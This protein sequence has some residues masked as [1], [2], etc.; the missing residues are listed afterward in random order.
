MIQFFC[1]RWGQAH[2][3]WNKFLDRVKREGYDGIEAGSNNTKEDND[4]MLA[5]LAKHGLGL[6]AQH[7][8]TVDADIEKHA[9]E[10]E[11]RLM[12]L[13][14]LQPLF[15]NTHTGK[16]H[17]TFEENKRLI[18]IAFSIS[19]RTGIKIIHETHR[20]RFGFAAHIARNYLQRIPG[21]RIT[22]DV[23]HWCNTAESLLEDQDEAVA[24]ALSHTDHI[25]ARIGFAQGPQVPDPRD[26]RWANEMEF[27]VG[28]WDKIIAEKKRSGSSITITPEFGPA[29]YMMHLP[30][31]EKPLADQWDINLFIMKLLKERYL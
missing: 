1:P 29:P 2:I 23:S 12:G 10:F 6:I 13:A 20:G 5:G 21:L 19:G 8:E 16:D 11:E 18:D 22:F 3:P 27:H 7:W 17:F 31:S 28:C 24:L 25:H 26:P 15:I 30:F 14:S 9:F 4:E